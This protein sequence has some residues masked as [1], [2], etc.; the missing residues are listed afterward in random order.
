MQ[1]LKQLKQTYDNSHPDYEHLL[2]RADITDKKLNK[3]KR[4]ILQPY[5]E[6][7]KLEGR[8]IVYKEKY[9]GLVVISEV[10]MTEKGFKASIS[11]AVSG[12]DVGL[13][14]F[15]LSH[16]TT[17]NSSAVEFI[18]DDMTAS[19]SFGSVGTLAE[20][21]AGTKRFISGIPYYNSGSP[22]LTVSGTTINNLVGQA[23][24]DQ[25]NIVE[26]D[27]GTNAEG[28]SGSAITNTDYTYANI[29]GSTTMLSGDNP[30]ANTGTSS[31]YAIGNLTVPIT[32]SSRRT[33]EQL[34]IRARNVNGISSYS[35]LTST[36]VQ[37]HT[38]AQSD[39]SE[40]AIAVAD[41]LGATYDD[42]GVRIFDLS[43]ATTNTPT[44]SGSANFYT[45][46][47]YSLLRCV[48]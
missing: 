32:S 48:L 7:Q 34:R 30:K 29:D 24:T 15:Q 12:L 2:N 22:T 23:F 5:L 25:S 11:K 18:K 9:A 10:E 37:V 4:E 40:I 21:T 26:I 6:E 47:L 41:A 20:G 13:N 45:N 16:S 8:V 17:G 14:K 27:S 44:Y 46:S 35:D 38:A 33:V 19:P 28:T 31:A 43:S 39:I 3:I 1:T 42:D 36:K